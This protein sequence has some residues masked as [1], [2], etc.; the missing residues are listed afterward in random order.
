MRARDHRKSQLSCVTKLQQ[1]HGGL[2]NLSRPLRLIVLLFFATFVTG[3]ASTS[4]QRVP[5]IPA[6]GSNLQERV[7]HSATPT[8]QPVASINRLPRQGWVDSKQT[9]AI[10]DPVIVSQLEVTRYFLSVIAGVIVALVLVL[11]LATLVS[12]CLL[13]SLRSLV[14]YE[15]ELLKEIVL[16]KECS[17]LQ[18]KVQSW[19]DQ[20]QYA[21]KLNRID[22][23]GERFQ[24]TLVGFALASRCAFHIA[25]AS[26]G[27]NP[28]A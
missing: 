7:L 26:A 4:Y 23:F 1:K 20:C 11:L 28:G 6:N 17:A 12:F 3:C 15:F 21:L 10:P 14:N 16:I 25:A 8:K 19:S 22:S 13:Q 9:I 24:I 2:A 5:A 18:E 27:R